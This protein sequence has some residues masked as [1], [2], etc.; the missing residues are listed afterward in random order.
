MPGKIT[1]KQKEILEYIK[2]Q[3]LAKGYP[4]ALRDICEAVHLRSTSSVH[5]HLETLEQNGYIRRDPAK[6]RAIEIIDDDFNL[7][8]REI[9]NVPMIGTITAGQPILAVESIENYFPIPF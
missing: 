9:V 6:P 5:A 7:T 1:N 4:P 8:K 2:E 3:I